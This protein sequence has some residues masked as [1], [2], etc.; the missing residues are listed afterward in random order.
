MT[1]P[2]PICCCGFEESKHP[3]FSGTC[4][5][6]HPYDESHHR[7]PAAPAVPT[8]PSMIAI[9][10]PTPPTPRSFV[11]YWKGSPSYEMMAQAAWD[12]GAKALGLLVAEQ[13]MALEIALESAPFYEAP[14]QIRA[15]IGAI[16]EVLNEKPEAKAPEKA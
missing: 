14:S 12:A 7:L 8:R 11:E 6:F 10:K 16:Y 15:A 4:A 1:S 3:L 13:L 2:D 9:H 5:K